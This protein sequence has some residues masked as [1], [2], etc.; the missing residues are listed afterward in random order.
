VYTF[1]LNTTTLGYAHIL[2]GKP[3]PLLHFSFSGRFNSDSGVYKIIVIINA[4]LL[5]TLAIIPL[6]LASLQQQN[7]VLTSAVMI[8][9]CAK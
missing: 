3:F 2:N 8:P 5:S 7:T 6:L 4:T 1:S 9:V